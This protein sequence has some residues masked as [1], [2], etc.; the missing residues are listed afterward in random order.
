[1]SKINEVAFQ[2]LCVELSYVGF[3]QN[4]MNWIKQR[5]TNIKV[6]IIFITS[7]FQ[8]LNW[9]ILVHTQPY[10][11]MI[12][13]T[14]PHGTNVTIWQVLPSHNIFLLQDVFLL[15]LQS[16]SFLSCNK[17][18]C[19]LYGCCHTQIFNLSVKINFANMLKIVWKLG[20]TL[21]LVFNILSKPQPQLNS[22][23]T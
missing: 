22:T 17:T 19:T 5:Q 20:Q 23:L 6:V 1:M 7:I 21:H 3:W 13:V 8:N 10:T 12:N 18:F 9:N 4:C 15:I 11:P 2:L 14:G 16:L